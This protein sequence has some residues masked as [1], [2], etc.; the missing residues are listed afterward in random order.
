MFFKKKSYKRLKKGE[1]CRKIFTQNISE[2]N[3]GIV[4]N[5]CKLKLNKIKIKLLIMIN[6]NFNIFLASIKRAL[7]NYK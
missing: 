2:K 5:N 1:K 4:S 7:Q 6:G 3:D